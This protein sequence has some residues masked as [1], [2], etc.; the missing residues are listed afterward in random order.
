M[1]ES[2]QVSEELVKQIIPQKGFIKDYLAYQESV[3][4]TP[5]W[6]H[7]GSLLAMVSTAASD[8]N[9]VVTIKDS[10]A[11]RNIPSILYVITVGYS[12]SRKTEA[13]HRAVD[14]LYRA[15]D[16]VGGSDASKWKGAL[17]PDD[18][19]EEAL[20]NHL[21]EHPNTLLFKEELSHLFAS[22]TKSYMAS[23]MSYL[24]GLYS[25]NPKS[26]KTMSGGHIQVTKP[27]LN[28]LGAIPPATLAEMGRGHWASGYLARYMFFGAHPERN[29]KMPRNDAITE[30]NFA[31]WLQEVII[32]SSGR[33]KVD[34]S[35]LD[36]ILEWYANRHA[37]MDKNVIDDDELM[38]L[39][40]RFSD[41]A[42]KTSF[43]ACL[44][45]QTNKI[46]SERQSIW[47][48][49]E[50]VKFGLDTIQLLAQSE[51]ALFHRMHEDPDYA[52]SD[53]IIGIVSENQG[54]Y[55]HELMRK[56]RDLKIKGSSRTGIYRILN[57]M[58]QG[59]E[60]CTTGANRVCRLHT[61]ESRVK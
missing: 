12:G 42:I 16:T 6:Y 19:T 61:A 39:T 30:E 53:K 41:H 44:C 37:L 1:L 40:A 55:R 28:I 22:G 33:V 25:G 4:D 27:R 60:L 36:P 48:E 13:N 18:I 21:S 5:L 58:I 23:M 35:V 47:V 26:R 50:D 38:S 34:L 56:I 17:G 43:V 24:T 45:R 57:T 59:N 9:W 46:D 31:K 20:H 32:R 3:T 14:I 52:I 29:I 8:L 15:T 10:R 2:W 49:P 7:V 54:I 11:T 51:V